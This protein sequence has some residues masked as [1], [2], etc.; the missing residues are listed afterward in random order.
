MEKLGINLFGLMKIGSK[1][2]QGTLKAIKDAGFD[3]VELLL[4]PKKRQGLLPL[5]LTSMGGL[6]KLMS[7]LNEAGLTA[8]SAHVFG[9]ATST[10]S[11]VDM[12]KY[13]HNEH[14]I[15]TFVFSGMFKDAK[16]ADEWAKNLSIIVGR[17]NDDG[18]R[19]LYHNHSQEFSTVH[20]LRHDYE[21]MTALD[22]FFELADSSIGLQLDI[23]WAGICCDEVEL[24]KKYADKICSLHLKDFVAGTRNNFTNNNMP[25]D[26][27][28][29]IGC[30]EIKTAE[31]V[32]MRDSF[33]NFNGS[34]TIDQDHSADM[35]S[36]IKKGAENVRSML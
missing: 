15:D 18:C 13:A 6:P 12:I 5:M 30:G 14:G 2:V 21:E 19:I 32:A 25:R 10:K 34:I 29:A 1:N 11:V 17:V 20:V 27:F 3:E 7:M 36:D 24:A 9:S 16:G 33:P 31:L 23:G 28:C 8:H 26:R 35:L 4:V 22:Y